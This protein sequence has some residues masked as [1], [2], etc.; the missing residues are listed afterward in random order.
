M[1]EI[2]EGFRS[3]P[4]YSSFA[5][6]LCSSEGTVVPKVCVLRDSTKQ[7]LSLPPLINGAAT[8]ITPNTTDIFV[9]I[10]SA[11]SL[12]ACKQMMGLFLGRLAA[13]LQGE[14]VIKTMIVEPVAVKTMVVAPA[15]SRRK[16]APK[17]TT[18]W[19]T[20]I[21]PSCME[22]YDC[23]QEAADDSD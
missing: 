6:M 23:I 9:E 4:L 11:S 17:P 22:D 12:G 2:V 18:S 13:H 1:V 3:D 5:A 15:S 16:G 21:F 20:T 19:Q 14:N 7:V 10:S 8:A